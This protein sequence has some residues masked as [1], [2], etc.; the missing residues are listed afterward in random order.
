[1]KRSAAF[2]VLAGVA[3]LL[4]AVLVYSTLKGREAEIQRAIASNV[5]IVVAS[6]DLPLGT[7]IDATSVKMARWSRDSLPPGAFTDPAPVLNTFVKSALVENEPL[8]PGKLFMGEKTAGVMPLLIPPGMRAMSVPVDEVS[9]IAGFVLPHSRVDILVALSSAGGAQK[10]FSKLVLQNVEVLAVAQ[11]VEGKKDEPEVVKVVTLLVSPEEAERLALASHEGTLR[12]AMRNYS[13]DKIVMT[14][15]TDIEDMLRSYSVVPLIA[16]QPSAAH[17]AV[18]YVRPSVQIEIMRDGKSRQSISFVGEPA[19]GPIS[20][21]RL[22][23]VAD[24]E[25]AAAKSNGNEVRTK[26]DAEV[27]DEHPAAAT[28]RGSEQPG[29]T[30]KSNAG[31]GEVSASGGTDSGATLLGGSDSGPPF[32]IV[33]DSGPASDPNRKT[34]DV[35]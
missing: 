3:G 12:L 16:H 32:V 27:A 1:M 4:C 33:K 24:A 22:R 13:D 31:D 30:N 14:S 25:T 5:Q 19:I 18:G 26:A 6:R 2:L 9:D 23:R 29:A 10:P 7:K 15:G 17:A 34:I 11:E 20:G 35:P 21:R 8:V 28:A